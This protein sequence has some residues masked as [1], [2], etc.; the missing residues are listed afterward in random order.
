MVEVFI[1]PQECHSNVKHLDP[2]IL[3]SVIYCGCQIVQRFMWVAPACLRQEDA[4]PHPGACKY[5]LHYDIR[6]DGCFWVGIGTWNV[7][8]LSG[9]TEDV[10][11]ELR[12]RRINVCCLQEVGWRGHGSMMLWMVGRRYK[13][14]WSEKGDGFD[15]V[16]VMVLEE[17]VEIGRVSDRM[18]AVLLVFEEDALWLICGCA[19]QSRSLEKNRLFIR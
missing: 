9:S 7:G 16:G 11:E 14:C 5:S 6:F 8:S 12:K 19:L 17:V 4:A 3:M 18:I 13:L 1:G 10:C 2:Q 15:G